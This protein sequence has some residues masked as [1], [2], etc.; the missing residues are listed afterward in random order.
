MKAHA[1]FCQAHPNIQISDLT[2]VAG[3]RVIRILFPSN[4]SFCWRPDSF[5][6]CLKPSHACAY[7]W[8]S[9]TRTSLR[10][11]LNVNE[12]LYSYKHQ[13]T[14]WI[15]SSNLPVSFLSESYNS[16][17]FQ[18]LQQTFLAAC[19]SCVVACVCACVR[20]GWVR[21][22]VG[23]TG[24]VGVWV[25]RCVGAWVYGCVGVWE[26]G[27]V[28]VWVCGWLVTVIGRYNYQLRRECVHQIWC[29]FGLVGWHFN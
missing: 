5:K 8:P 12:L 4:F 7:G 11:S 6:I 13:F 14:L 22:Y 24:C 26:C 16:Q 17:F 3:E 2:S 28:G 19:D 15:P 18:A 25:C 27:C 10:V 21:G 20:L 29:L 1:S 9:V 23:D